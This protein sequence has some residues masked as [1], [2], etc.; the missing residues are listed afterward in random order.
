MAKIH[1]THP[2]LARPKPGPR[3]VERTRLLERLESTLA[4]HAGIW[5]ASPAG[6]GKTTLI[7][8]FLQHHD[9]QYIWYQLDPD[10]SD[11]AVFF[12]YLGIA[13]SPFCKAGDPPL[14]HLTPEYTLGVSTFARRFFQS[15]YALF[16]ERPF[17]LVFDNYQRLDSH[18]VVHELLAEAMQELPGNGR[19]V[20]A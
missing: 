2:K 11:P 7:S 12:E 8:D 4:T 3:I 1:H 19:V 10:D 14:P 16:R 15:F 18:S 5:I 9:Y 6:A 20:V 13:A 17:V